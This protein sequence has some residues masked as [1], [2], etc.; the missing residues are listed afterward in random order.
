MDNNKFNKKDS[1]KNCFRCGMTALAGLPNAGKST[2]LNAILGEKIAIT[3]SKPQTTRNAIIGI[4]TTDDAQIIYVDTPG[5]HTGGGKMNRA[6]IRQTEEAILSV[7]IV[8]V[9]ADPAERRID[10][11]KTLLEKVNAGGAPVILVITKTDSR[12]K[13]DIYRA[14]E[15]LSKLALFKEIVPV[16]AQK[17]FNL[18]V[19]EE[20]I[21]R[22]LP[23]AP[24]IYN[25]DE[26]TTHP[27]SFIISEFIRE[28][29][30]TL[31]NQEVPYDILVET[32][33]VEETDGKMKITAAIIVSRDSQKGIV[34]GKGGSMLKEIG[35]R[36]RKELEKFFG[37]KIRL[38]IWVKVKEDWSSKDDYL[39]IQGLY[40]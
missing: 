13:E 17:M 39:R 4:K 11:F 36:A 6:M 22:E 14:A 29:A 16:S 27:E 38:D 20:L 23:I 9:L 1:D 2:L 5:Y 26:L 37:M 18:G 40:K 32:E 31:L 35:S 8:C 19:L 12:G 33:K 30:F 3:S 28:Q 21:I 7:N 24:P 15:S 10:A 25:R 34:I